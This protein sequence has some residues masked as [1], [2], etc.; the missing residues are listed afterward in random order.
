MKTIKGLLK[1]KTF[2]FNVFS[3]AAGI[4]AVFSGFLPAETLSL[5]SAAGNIGLRILTNQPLSEK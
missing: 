1:S 4:P 5:I 3:V 2:W